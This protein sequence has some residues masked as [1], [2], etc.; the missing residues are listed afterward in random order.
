MRRTCLLSSLVEHLALCRKRSRP[1]H[2]IIQ[3]LAT[4][5]NRLDCLVL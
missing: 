2:E 1:L 3:L 5:Q 4:L